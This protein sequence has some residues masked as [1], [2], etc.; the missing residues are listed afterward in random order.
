MSLTDAQRER[1]SRNIL[2]KGLGEA[3]QKKLL[4]SRV[5]VIGA[6]GLGSPAILYLAA[7]GIGTLG[8]ADG[9]RAD[10]SNLQRQIL[11]TMS[12]IGKLKAESA[13]EKIERLNS[14]VKV[15]TY[16]E[17]ITAENIR[18]I[19]GDYDFVV[20][21]TDNSTSKF[22]I[23]DA[24]VLLNKPFSHCGVLGFS[25]RIMTYAP[26]HACVRCVFDEPMPGA[27][28]TSKDVG[29]LG[30]VAGTLGAIQAGEAIKFVTGYGKPLTG[31][32]LHVDLKDGIFKRIT[33]KPDRKCPICGKNPTTF[34][35]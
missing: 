23:N 26:G 28:P 12:D 25:G 6:G 18:A 35:L 10:V 24:C 20:E 3:G 34:S 2:I 22:L 15:I 5:L 29:I 21:C 27:S 19:I 1:Y 8:V 17:R 30:A 32:L 13:K 11:H 16:P 33:V 7:A 4:S 31:T 14:D 9:D